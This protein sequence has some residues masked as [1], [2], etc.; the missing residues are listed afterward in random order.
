MESMVRRLRWTNQSALG[1][2][3][4][5][6]RAWGLSRAN[7]IEEL[8]DWQGNYLL[9]LMIPAAS[10]T[11]GALGPV[12]FS[13]GL[14]GYV[15]SACGHSVTL[16]HRL[17]RHLRR[18]KACRWHIDF[19]TS[20]AGVAPVA[21]YVSVSSSL[22][23]ERLARLCAER[24]PVIARFGNSDLRAKTPGHLFLLHAGRVSRA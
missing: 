13:A 22:S 9:L 7:R 15:G 6:F 14:Y 1:S 10:I 16:A 17:T 2:L 18:E 8:A 3:A 11:V 20:H 23:E 21:A 4:K 19:V 5:M 24:F 12:R